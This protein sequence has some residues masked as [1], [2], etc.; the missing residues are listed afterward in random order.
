MI[1]CYS[2]QA[3]ID[4]WSKKKFTTNL[5]EDG[6]ESQLAQKLKHRKMRKVR[7]NGFCVI[8]DSIQYYLM[9]SIRAPPIKTFYVSHSY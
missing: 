9:F 3:L 8:Y 7:V 1:V 4:S 2:I 6:Q 5:C